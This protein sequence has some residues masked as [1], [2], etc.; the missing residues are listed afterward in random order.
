ML[1]SCKYCG[2]VHDSSVEC[3]AAIKFK[4]M[5]QEK[6]RGTVQKKLRGTNKWTQKSIQIRKRDGNM[7]LCCRANLIG[8]V[9]TLNTEDLSVHHIVPLE[10]NSDGLLDD[11]NLITV[12]SAH[13]ELCE[14]GTIS[15]D[16]QRDLVQRSIRQDSMMR[17]VVY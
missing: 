4:K 17:Q 3:E 16:I 15:R 9:N 7:C 12:C 8:T 14:N 13:H 2:R 11:E 1:K 6:N 10:E 5:L